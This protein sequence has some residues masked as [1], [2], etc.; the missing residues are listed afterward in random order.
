LPVP[1]RATGM[2]IYGAPREGADVFDINAGE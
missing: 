2:S 1:P